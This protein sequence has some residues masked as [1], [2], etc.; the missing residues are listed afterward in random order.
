MPSK[1]IGGENQWVKLA[2]A[3]KKSKY[4]EERQL[5]R[6][7]GVRLAEMAL[8]SPLAMAYALVETAALTAE[9]VRRLVA[10]LE[11]K[12]VPCYEVTPTLYRKI[13]DTTS[14]QGVMLIMK[15]PTHSLSDS[16]PNSAG[17]WVALEGVQDPGNVGTIIRTADA[18]GAAGILAMPGTADIFADKVVRGSMGSVFNLPIYE[19]V[20]QEAL[21]D[22]CQAK[23]LTLYAAAVDSEAKSCY[24][25][26]FAA[27]TVLAFGNEG[28]GLSSELLA[29]AQKIYI[30]MFGQA[31]SLNVGA[32]AAVVLYEWT[33]QKRGLSAYQGD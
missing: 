12:N 30:P 27:A 18:C 26:D 3:L 9:R 5:F 31:E 14:P 6:A 17:L 20:T 1:I 28:N 25:V 4:R 7:E 11:A 23:R 15:K 24:R 10:D 21:Q 8:A 2:T 32:A 22:F 29:R 16:P 13:S 33:R 19:D